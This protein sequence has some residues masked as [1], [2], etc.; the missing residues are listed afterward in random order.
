MSKERLESLLRQVQ[1]R[2]NEPRVR[3]TPAAQAPVA[4]VATAPAPSPPPRAP[5]QRS[6]TPLEQAVSR[7]SG[8]APTAPASTAPSSTAPKKKSEPSF[9]SPAAQYARQNAKAK[10]VA[11]APKPKSIKPAPKKPSFSALKPASVKPAP[12]A[13]PKAESIAVAPAVVPSAPITETRGEKPAAKTF[14]AL[15]LRALAL[16][17]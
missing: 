9:D 17:P 10:S 4:A 5:R 2:R 8:F 14:G 13:A 6:A 7:A 15:I 1:E 3:S 12:I 16:R 11:P